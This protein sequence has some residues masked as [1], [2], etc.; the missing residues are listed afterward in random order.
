MTISRLDSY[1]GAY[2]RR[3]KGRIGAPKAVTATAR[4]LAIICYRAVKAGGSLKRLT[5]EDYEQANRDRIL[6]AL[7]QRAARL[8][9]D[10]TEKSPV[11]VPA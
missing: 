8:G 6:H 7:R 1:L 10:L 3:L 9:F 4:K 11:P 2:C 5:A